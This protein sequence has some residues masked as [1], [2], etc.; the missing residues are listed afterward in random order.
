MDN[1]KIKRLQKKEWLT[2]REFSALVDISASKLRYYDRRGIFCPAAHGDGRMRR[3]R[4]YSPI[5]V[6]SVKII[7][8]LSEIGVSLEEIAELAKE[9]TPG[10]IMKLLARN[11]RTISYE[12]S[13]LN[14]VYSIISIYHDM[15][16]EGINADEGDIA[17]CEMP[18]MT[19]MLGDPTDFAEG[20]GFIREFQSFCA[21]PRS[22]RLNLSFPVGGYFD[23]IEDFNEHPSEPSRF[24]S[25]DPGGR[26]QKE[27]GLYLVAYTRGYYGQVNDL[28]Q[29]MVKYAKEHKIVFD[30]PVYNLYLFNE[31][32]TMEPGQYLLQV[33]S[34]IKETEHEFTLHP[35]RH[36]QNRK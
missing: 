19:I 29:R 16:I 13:Y 28:P 23:S 36:F 31:I 8:V 32:S 5:Q 4:Y 33:S 15:I 6:T 24:F 35:H 22:P 7:R 25:L 10:K 11:K 14:A 2:I 17:V 18:E 3:V 1:E 9:R 20:E 12:I 27:K 21:K 26:E 34:A 30:G